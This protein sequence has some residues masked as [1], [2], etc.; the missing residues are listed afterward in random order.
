MKSVKKGFTLIELLVVVAIIAILAAI[1]I[2][3]FAKYRQNAYNSAANSDIRNA[4][5]ALESYFADKQEYPE[6]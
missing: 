2:P 4:K 1:A 3:Q 5:T 6:D